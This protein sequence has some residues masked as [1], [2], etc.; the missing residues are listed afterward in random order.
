MILLTWSWMRAAGCAEHLGAELLLVEV[1]NGAR[2]DAHLPVAQALD[3]DRDPAAGRAAL[4][5]ELP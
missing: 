3:P 5:E 2:L 1:A 4:R